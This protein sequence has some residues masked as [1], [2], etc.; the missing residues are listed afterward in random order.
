MMKIGFAAPGDAPQIAAIHLAAFESDA[1]SRLVDMLRGD[2]DI[3]LSLVAEQGG[4][5]V[6][7][8]ILS[9]RS[10]MSLRTASEFAHGQSGPLAFCPN[11]KARASVV[12]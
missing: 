5:L 8:N 1:E 3:A 9:S 11:C 4:K 7:S 2:G 6:G 10:S 12:L